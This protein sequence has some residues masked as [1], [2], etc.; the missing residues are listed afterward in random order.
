MRNPREALYTFIGVLEAAPPQAIERAA[1]GVLY[2]YRTTIS[3]ALHDP[4]IGNLE[5]TGVTI[6]GVIAPRSYSAPRL[7]LKAA[8]LYGS[9]P[10]RSLREPLD[11]YVSMLT[12]DQ[13]EVDTSITMAKDVLRPTYWDDWKKEDVETSYRQCIYPE[14]LKAVVNNL[15]SVNSDHL[16][17][18]DLFGGDGEFA[19]QLSSTLLDIGLD[20]VVHIIDS[21]IKSLEDAQSRS[22]NN[23]ETLVVHAPTD[24][25][26]SKNIFPDV[27]IPPNIVTVVG[28]LCDKVVTRP[29]AIKVVGKIYD[30]MAEGGILVVTGYREVLLN[31]VDFLR[32][33]FSEVVQMS[34][35]ENTLSLT[36]PYQMYVVR[37]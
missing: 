7:G 8:A 20:P 14:T 29:D 17:C 26:Y 16:V 2:T 10:E 6:E 30:G 12:G 11:E 27:L 31:S 23:P 32:A 37:K 36:P 15:P 5:V 25:L 9:G 35:P 28:G 34:I 33:G 21:N 18:A 1:K 19:E 3:T 13:V 4:A 24:L 22:T